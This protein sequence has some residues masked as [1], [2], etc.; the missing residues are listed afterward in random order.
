MQAGRQVMSRTRGHYPAP[1]AAID[2]VRTGLTR[3]VAAGLAREAQRFGELAVGAVSRHLVQIFF[4]TTTLKKDVGVDLHA[5]GARAVE[6]LGVVGGGFMGTAI[7]GVAALRAGVD[8]RLR[9]TDPG[10]V[11]R[12][13]VGAR[14]VLDEARTR[15]RLD[16]HE[17]ARRAAL[18]SGSTDYSGFRRRDLV[19]E[20]VFEDLDVKRRVITEIEEVVGDD[21]VVASNTSTLPIGGLQQS[22]RRP[23]R[24]VGM[25]FFSPVQKMPLLEIVRGAAT[26]ESAVATAVRFGQRLGKTAIV[27]GDAPGFWV[28]RILAPYLNEAGWL[29]EEGATIETIDRVS[30]SFGF[31]V[32]PFTL[33]DEVGLDVADKA[34]GV[35][36][37]ALGARLAPPPA[38]AALVRD[39]RLGRKSGAGFYR[40]RR[41]RRRR[42]PSLGRRTRRRGSAPPSHRDVERRLV[43]ALVNEAARAFAEG[44]VGR[45]RDGDIGA[46]LGFGFPPFL[47]G[48][49]RYVDDCGA[50]ALVA[51]LERYAAAAG[52]RFAPAESLVEL[53]RAGGRFHEARR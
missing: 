16:R 14:R 2:A 40:Y 15:R 1:L 41:G 38:I 18:L 20:A 3:G 26:A 31:P 9:D 35:L 49:L 28:N 25:H 47:G 52:P 27:V 37:E 29:L 4:A 5:P 12:G 42:D 53:A 13:V 44:V 50:S 11:A 7:A 23:E 34:S 17:H 33:L 43:L 45:A 32:G 8:V 30:V 10:R 6:R 24:I 51:E 46:I 19:I 21:C 48:P 39:G 22:A 36:H